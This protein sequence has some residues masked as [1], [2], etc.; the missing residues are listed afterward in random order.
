[1]KL[2][3]QTALVTGGGAG[4]GK[5]IALRFAQEGARVAVW[6]WDAARAE[7]VAR[8]IASAGG[9]AQAFACDVMDVNAVNNMARQV[10]E[11]LGMVD[12]LVNSAGDAIVGG[13]F[14]RFAESTAA[15]MNKLVGVNLMGTYHAGRG[16]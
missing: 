14:Q 10:R 15:Y 12:I 3:N 9:T 2:Q 13:P 4:I 11:G 1:M 16:K 6:D 5:A 7:N 8:E